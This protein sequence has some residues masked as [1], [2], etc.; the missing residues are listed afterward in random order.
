MGRRGGCGGV[1]VALPKLKFRKIQLSLPLWLWS[2]CL[3]FLGGMNIRYL[4]FWFVSF[5]YLLKLTLLSLTKTLCVEL[6]IITLKKTMKI[7]A[8]KGRF[9]DSESSFGELFSKTDDL[10]GESPSPATG[11]RS[12][13]R[14]ETTL[15]EQIILLKEMLVLKEE[16]LSHY[17]NKAAAWKGATSKNKK[18]VA[19]SSPIRLF[20]LDSY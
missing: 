5:L 15:M 18:I 11:P 8:E 6:V 13:T 20:I 19:A 17:Q 3:T 16:Q 7:Q 10:V 2:H 1:G 4:M 9:F 12:S 14:E